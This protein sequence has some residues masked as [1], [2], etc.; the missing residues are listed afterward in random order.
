MVTM[1]NEVCRD[2]RWDHWATFEGGDGM[3]LRFFTTEESPSWGVARDRFG[4][5]TIG[6]ELMGLLLMGKELDGAAGGL[7]R[8]SFTVFGF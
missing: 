3:F 6:G 5:P 8:K 7:P 4:C 2:V 1:F